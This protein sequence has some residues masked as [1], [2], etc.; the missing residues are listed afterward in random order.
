[1]L[2]VSSKF[3]VTRP[4]TE[5]ASTKERES[6]EGGTVGQAVTFRRIP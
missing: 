5:F 2:V 4:V 3:I 6:G 1:M